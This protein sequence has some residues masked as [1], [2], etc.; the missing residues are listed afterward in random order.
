MD[1]SIFSRNERYAIV[2]ILSMIMEADTVIHPKEIEYMD[3]VFVDFSIT[4]DDNE[5]MY[6]MD[7]QMCLS[8]IRNMT[9]EKQKVAKDMF[10][11]MAAIDGFVDPREKKLIESL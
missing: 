11:I 8:I 6:N 7:M 4:V 2:N 3:S 1:I 9:T 5:H 10:S